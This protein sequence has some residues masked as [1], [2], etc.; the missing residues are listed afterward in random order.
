MGAWWPSQNSFTG[1]GPFEWHLCDACKKR[2]YR[3]DV[4]GGMD[5]HF[6]EPM[7][8][9]AVNWHQRIAREMWEDFVVGSK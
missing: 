8:P 1:V 2:G 9:R 3:R 7:N 5:R 6:V 4:G